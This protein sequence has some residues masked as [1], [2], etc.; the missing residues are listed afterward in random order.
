MSWD[1]AFEKG[2][3]SAG[4][5]GKKEFTKFPEGI[6]K[7]R[8]IGQAPHVRWTHWMPA[9][10]LKGVTGKGRTV[11]C[12]GRGC[13]ICEIIKALKEAEAKCPYNTTQAFAINVLNRETK[14]EE[15]LEKGKTF[16]EDLRDIRLEGLKPSDPDESPVGDMINYDIKVKRTGLGQN[17]TKYRIDRDKVYP[18][19]AEEEEIV[20][21]QTN[22]AEYYKPHT[23][24]QLKRLLA[25]EE[26][27]DVF[28]SETSRDE[29]STEEEIG[30]E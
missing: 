9:S 2:A 13:P 24:E 29:Q 20:K 28:A 6:T 27:N 21:N 11:N 14:R 7:L 10:T 22:L 18:L 26:W 25:G 8:V 23:V 12:P 16:F 17:D 3:G 15:I 30:I 19:T 4:G 5:S 1:T